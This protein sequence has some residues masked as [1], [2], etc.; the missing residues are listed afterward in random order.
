MS[1]LAVIL[2][3]GYAAVWGAVVR[4]LA[5]WYAYSPARYQPPNWD[6]AYPAAFFLGAVWPFLIFVAVGARFRIGE[7]RNV[8]R[9]ERIAAEKRELARLEQEF[10]DIIAERDEGMTTSPRRGFSSWLRS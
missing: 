10:D 3:V 2:Y 9:R 4:P 5:G 6:M 8:L 1:V 7:E